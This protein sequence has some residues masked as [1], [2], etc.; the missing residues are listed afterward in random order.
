MK[1]LIALLCALPVVLHA[2]NYPLDIGFS[3]VLSGQLPTGW[4]GDIAVMN[5][6][7][8][9]DD[10]GLSGLVS[11]GDKE[12]SVVTDWV[13]P[14]DDYIQIIF[15]HRLVDEFIYPSTEK[16]L[17]SDKLVLSMSN[18]GLNFSPI[19][20]IDS[21]NHLASLNFKKIDFNLSGHQ[22]ETV[23]FKFWARHG[24]G[25]SYYV[26]IDSIKVRKDFPPPAGLPSSLNAEPFFTLFPNP[27]TQGQALNLRFSKTVFQHVVSIYNLMGEKIGTH[28]I[29]GDAATISP[30]LLPGIYVVTDENL[31]KKIVVQ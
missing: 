13:G 24:K 11:G 25:S 18:D 16:N 30:G 10:K 15:W 17:T 31:R 19:Y 28:T 1:H 8:L 21:T 6:H 9:N 27:V 14:L 29:N 5:Y 3:N 22:G 7:G 23:K 4:S 26:D 2:Q 12:D 20:T